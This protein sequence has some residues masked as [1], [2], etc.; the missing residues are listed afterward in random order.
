MLGVPIRYWQARNPRSLFP[1]CIFPGHLSCKEIQNPLSSGLHTYLLMPPKIIRIVNLPTS[2]ARCKVE[3]ATCSTF[4]SMF[5]S[6]Y[7]TPACFL[8]SNC[9][10]CR[11][12]EFVRLGVTNLR[13][14]P[15]RIEPMR[16]DGAMGGLRKDFSELVIVFKLLCPCK[17]LPVAAS[18]E[19]ARHGSPLLARRR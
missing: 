14:L 17:P 6:A 15:R 13:L 19:E 16:F 7:V 10:F 1:G 12:L 3:E 11:V 9:P 18:V 4:P 5:L 8:V 2:H